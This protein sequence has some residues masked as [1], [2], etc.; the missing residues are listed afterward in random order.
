MIVQTWSQHVVALPVAFP[1]AG[2]ALTALVFRRNRRWQGLTAV[3]FM[4]LG[5]I[6][7][8]LL[9]GDV[10]ISGEPRVFHLG[11]WPAPFGIALAGDLLGATMAFMCQIVLLGGVVYGV[12]CRDKCAQFPTFF[13][14]FLA[15][16][17]GLTGSMLTTDIFNLFV[18]AE[19]V[20][21]AGTVLTAISDDRKGTEA[22]FKYFYISQFAAMALLVACGTLYAAYGTLNMADL[23]RL[24]EQTPYHPLLPFA[25]VLL[26]VS[27]MIKSAVMPFHFWQPD[28]H[29]AAPTPV[30]AVLS[31]VVVKLGI[32][33]FMRMTTLLFIEP[34]AK[35]LIENTLIVCGC[36]GVIFGGLGA[37]GTYDAKRMLAY[38]T[39]GQLGFIL[40]AVGWG[41]PLAM[42]AAI[43]F[44]FNHSLAK[45]AMLMLAGAV[46][47]RAPVKTAAFDRIV[48]LG[49]LRPVAGILFLFGGMALAGLPPTNGFISKLAVLQ[50]GVE[51]G[52]WLP[53][54]VLAAA[55]IITLV[56]V[57]RAF[58]TIWLKP[59]PEGVEPKPYGDQL[60][61][62]FALVAG[63]LALGL[64]AQPLVELAILNSQWMLESRQEYI[65]A[66]IGTMSEAQ[67]RI[68]ELSP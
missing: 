41:T 9:L 55:S 7:S 16:A 24:I 15:L 40:V 43:I 13:P 49:R 51:A 29:T 68:Q 48:G 18:F 65:D 66:V 6:S 35:A 39:L 31:S 22:A 27:F 3:A 8:T 59:I 12:G 46:A 54:A 44:A 63:C 5:L 50:S 47:S 56:Y 17:A 33:G 42:A 36:A 10:L 23:A 45:A 60:L 30:H 38:S 2:C 52:Q 64:Y 67:D 61:A 19:V 1:L 26:L 21:I 62:P 34:E 53:L 14:F 25:M 28:F 32:Y 4:A 11:G 57:A 37:A 20:V 58:Q